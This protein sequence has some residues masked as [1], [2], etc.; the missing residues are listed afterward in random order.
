MRKILPAISPCPPATCM[1]CS[2]KTIRTSCLPS[3]PSGTHAAVTAELRSSS[4]PKSLSPMP[5]MPSLEARPRGPRRLRRVLLVGLLGSR[6][7]EVVAR[8]PGLPVHPHSPLADAY[9]PQARRRHERLLRACHDDVNIP[10]VGP[11]GAGPEARD[12]VHD[13]DHVRGGLREA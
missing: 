10:L 3:M 7:V 1:P 2:R 9:E 4:G 12:R 8:H 5:L 6:P 13:R 11:Q